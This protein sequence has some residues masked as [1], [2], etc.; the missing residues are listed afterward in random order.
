MD[1][2][3]EM[4]LRKRDYDHQAFTKK[5]IDLFGER[6]NTAVNIL[7][8]MEREIKWYKVELFTFVNDYV[9]IQG[10]METCSG[11]TLYT[12]NG[13]VLIDESNKTKYVN[14][15]RYCLNVKILQHGTI[16]ALI[17]HIAF[18]DTI[19]KEMSDEDIISTLRSGV[20]NENMALENLAL[21]DIMEKLSRPSTFESFDTS[22]LSEE[23][24]LRLRS[25]S[26]NL[27]K[28]MH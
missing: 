26:Q 16:E 4:L 23:Q 27:V 8:K 3:I 12:E 19:A 24:Y 15:V 1:L 10:E 21:S 11:D 5:I 6:L 9:V 28:R 17:Q 20:V 22:S 18:I 7:S 14:N 25:C 13:P 2:T